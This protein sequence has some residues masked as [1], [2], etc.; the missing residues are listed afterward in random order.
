MLGLNIASLFV[1]VGADLSD[2]DAKMKNIDKSLKPLEDVVNK[3]SKVGIAV[4]LALTG[5]G[6]A[7]EKLVGDA[8]KVDASLGSIALTMGVSEQSVRDLMLSMVDAGFTMDEAVAT[9]DAL[10]KAGVRNIDDMRKSAETYDM[11]SHAIGE[12]ADVIA[13]GLV[14]AMN[15]YKIPLADTSKHVDAVTYALKNTN[16]TFDEYSNFLTKTGPSMSKFGLSLEDTTAALVELYKKGMTGK[17]AIAAIEAAVKSA[18]P[19]LSEMADKA[20]TA[21]DENLHLADDLSIARMRLDELRSSQH[22]S[23]STMATA[24]LRVKDLTE[25]M[26]E[27]NKTIADY[28]TATQNVKTPSEN[29]YNAL[30]ITG[31]KANDAAKGLADAKGKTEEYAEI[32]EK[33]YTVFDTFQVELGKIAYNLGETL[34]PMDPINAGLITMGPALTG[35]ASSLKIINSVGGIGGALALGTTGLAIG[36]VVLGAW[37]LSQALAE[38]AKSLGA[39]PET[40]ARYQES[41]L[42]VVPVLGP[43]YLFLEDMNKQL[44]YLRTHPASQA[45]ETNPTGESSPEG[46]GGTFENPPVSRADARAMFKSENPHWHQQGFTMTDEELRAFLISKG[47]VPAFREGGTVPGPVGAPILAMVHGGEDITPPGGAIIHR[48]E[49][50]IPITINL[51]GRKIG[52]NLVR[53]II[54]DGGVRY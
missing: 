32:V 47:R 18:N 53:R 35:I 24:E 50:V 25:K 33:K 15:A 44:D 6:L 2:L 19:D 11:L 43:V 51:D 8:K 27:N 40:I 9:Y 20:A 12:S 36:A 41:W 31:G 14:P 42:N 7:S 39:G 5:V 13:T 23:N 22:V 46:Y 48:T 16:L 30:G 34:K 28:Q 29:F 54:T 37:G 45:T 3:L 52:E 38:I 26:D 21:A 17:Q 1:K 4:G 49:L 10:S